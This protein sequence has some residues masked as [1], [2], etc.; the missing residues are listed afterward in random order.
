MDW[1][2]AHTDAR[3]KAFMRELP[4][5][6]RF[7][8]GE[9]GVRLVH[10]SPRKVNEYLFEEKPASLYERLAASAECDVL[11]FGHTHRVLDPR[12]R[13]GAVRQL[14]LGGQAQGRR[15]ARR[16]RAAGG[17]PRGGCRPPIER[18]PYDAEA[19]AAGGRGRRPARGV[20]GQAHRCGLK[21]PGRPDLPRRV[22]A[23]GLGTFCLVFAGTGAVVVDR[24]AGGVIGHGGAAAASG[25]VVA[26]M[27]FAVGH[28]SGAHLNPA[29]TAGFATGRHF[30]LREVGPYWAAQVAG[31]L[32]ASL[33]LRALFGTAHGLGATH[34]A[35]VGQLGALVLEAGLTAVLMI[36]ILAV[37]TDTRAAGSLAA[38]AVGATIALEAL[39]LGPI[40][41]ASMNPARSLAPALVAGDWADL[42]LYLVGP[43]SGALVGVGIYEALR[44]A[45]H[46]AAA[47]ADAQLAVVVEAAPE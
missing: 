3:S 45:P 2:L 6:L 47:A 26:I 11:V 39:V 14:R 15:P 36:V 20:R 21:V 16:L 46:P 8:M 27:I 37:A 18:V 31:A 42:W 44:G 24:V 25:L 41:G 4:F 28:L 7:A 13:R 32:A 23:E 10:G 9:Q 40:T 22:A 1:T 35:H 34:P 43:I 12:V 17:A 33:A 30:P 38:L 19:V 5:D 29:V